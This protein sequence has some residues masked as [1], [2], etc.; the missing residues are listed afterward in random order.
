[1]AILRRSD[2]VLMC[3]RH[4]DREWV[5]DVWDFP[6]GHIAE[7]ET[8]QEALSR[9]LEEELGINIAV[10]SR[11]ADAILEFEAESTRLAV[12]VIDYSGPVENCSPDEHDELRWVSLREAT[13]LRLADPTFIP[14]IE[15]ALRP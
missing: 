5:P 7:G 4:P 11:P 2:S 9:E 3:H 12:W 10:P 1:M 6:G 15:R 14:L 8:P 13:E